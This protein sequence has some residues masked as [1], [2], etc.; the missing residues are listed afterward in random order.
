MSGRQPAEQSRQVQ[1]CT[2]QA[3]VTQP[4]SHGMLPQA[5]LLHCTHLL[6]RHDEPAPQAPQLTVWPQLL[7]A[8]PQ[9]LPLQVVASGSGVH[10]THMFV[11]VSHFWSAAQVP[12]LTF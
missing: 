10:E 4:T 5:G 6:L 1:V 12:Q 11:V 9:V 3:S 2:P 7:V 8:L